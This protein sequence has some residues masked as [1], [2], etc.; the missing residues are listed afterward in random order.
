MY[1]PVTTIKERARLEASTSKERKTAL[2]RMTGPSKEEKR[3]RLQ[4]LSELKVPILLL[5]GIEDRYIDT[6]DTKR[7][8]KEIAHASLVSLP[9]CGHY[10]HEEKPEDVSGHVQQWISALPNT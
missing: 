1:H 5:H 6:D 8:Q 2:I 4:K 10:P 3:T 7:L 9:S